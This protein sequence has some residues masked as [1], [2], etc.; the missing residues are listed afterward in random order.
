MLIPPKYTLTPKISKL[1]SSIEASRQV[2]DSIN[3]PIEV[4]TNIRRAST[5][6]SSL[7]SARIEGNDLTL[8]EI[9]TTP[10]ANQKRIEVYNVLKAFTFIKQREKKDLSANDILGIHKIVMDKISADAGKFRKE[11]EAIFNSA[12]IAI[13]MPPPPRLILSHIDRLLKYVNHGKE[14][15][16]PIKAC[17]AHYLFEKIHPFVDAN[18]RVGRLLIQKILMQGGYGMKGLLPIEEY[19]DTHRNDYYHGLEEPERDVT[20]YL[21]FMLEALENVASSTKQLVLQKK[22]TDF[23]DYLLPRR[24]EIYNIIKDHRMVNFDTLRRRFLNINARTL[25]YDLKQLAN[26]GLIRKRGNTKGVYYEIVASSIEPT[27]Y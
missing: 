18:G 13:Y 20:D 9:T 26:A 12:H 17:L 2:I 3:I 21:E 4:E 22:K 7:F 11:H 27:I 15:F 10:S 8:D 1:L 5:L 16:V 14:S 6:K 19:L 24:A 25:R 23:L